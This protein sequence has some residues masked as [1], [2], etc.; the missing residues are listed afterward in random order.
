LFTVRDARTG[1]KLTI[2]GWWIPANAASDKC[3]VLLHGYADAKVGAIAW[4][5]VFHD[6]NCNILAIDLRAHGESGGQFCTG[7]YFERDDVSQV[8]DQL[9]NLYPDQA[10]QLILFGPSLGAAIA[11]AVAIHR[12][13]ISSVIL[14]SPYADYERAI[15]AQIRLMGLPGG[16]LLR[17][18]LAIAQ[19]ISGTK[20]SEVRPVDLLRNINCPV[21]TIIGADDELL[22]ADEIQAI[23]RA[24]KSNPSSVF[25]LVENTGHLA[26]MAS[27]PV[28][29]EQKIRDFLSTQSRF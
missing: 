14:E 5:P 26:V 11:C 24:A 29:Y 18:A 7:G 20:F 23:K 28:E 8:I 16:S 10:R 22:D 17:A 19:K 21:L 15:A 6:L 1:Q 9:L 3:V 13:D 27:D 4:A 12:D 25:W 2:S